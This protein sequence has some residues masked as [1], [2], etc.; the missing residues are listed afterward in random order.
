[1]SIATITF[2]IA[3]ALFIVSLFS[4]RKLDKFDSTVILF[5]LIITYVLCGSMLCYK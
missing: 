1:M 3:L 4:S 5:L 2:G